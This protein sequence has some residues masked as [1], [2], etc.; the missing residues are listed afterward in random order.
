MFNVYAITNTV[1]G[2]AYIGQTRNGLDRWPQHL[3][4][5]RRG[6]HFNQRLQRAF[7]KYTEAAFVFALMGDYQTTEECCVAEAAAIANALAARLC[8][9]LKTQV[10]VFGGIMSAE[11]RQR[12]SL[13]HTGSGN[14]QYGKRGKDS[15][16]FGIKRLPEQRTRLSL[17]KIG[18]KNPAFG[19]PGTNRGRAMSDAAKAKLSA[20]RT[21]LTVAPEHRAAASVRMTGAG[22]PFFGRTHGEASRAKM[23]AA[24]KGHPGAMKGKR[25]S[26]ETKRKISAARKGQPSPNTGR[27]SPLRGRSLSEETRQRMS[28]AAR[29]R[30]AARRAATEPKA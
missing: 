2:H 1:S 24:H 11:V 29:E 4:D 14:S 30:W 13:S 12:M 23:S 21:G 7:T 27:P 19:K 8:Y 3:Y 6:T 17:A 15:A 25:H 16:N 22:N 20:A 28:R 10:T 5:L 9:N 26:E 18:E